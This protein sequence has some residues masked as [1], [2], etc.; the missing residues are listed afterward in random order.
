[1]S[2]GA[3]SD[4]KIMRDVA[5]L[6]AMPEIIA[7]EKMDGE[8]TTIFSGGCHPRSLDARYHPSRDWIKALAA[9]ISPQLA[10]NERIV[11]EYLFAQHSVTYDALPSYLLGFAW[12]VDGVVQGWDET[13]QRFGELGI[14][15]VSILYRGPYSDDAIDTLISRLDCAKQEGFVVRS[16]GRVDEDEMHAHLAKYVRADHV[17]SDTHWMNAQVGKTD[18][19]NGR[20]LP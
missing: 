2:P 7:T 4:D 20:V 16:A 12:I 13:Q 6:Q 15:S 19:L 11:G 9:G 10:S 18:W 5:T 14:H 8:N 3:T 17:Q 1:M